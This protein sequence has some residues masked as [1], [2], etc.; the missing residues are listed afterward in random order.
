MLRVGVGRAGE[1]ATAAVGVG[2]EMAG[3]MEMV[4]KEVGEVG[5]R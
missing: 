2:T 3:V 1:G 4:V 5:E